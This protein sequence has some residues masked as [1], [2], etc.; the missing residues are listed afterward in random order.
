MTFSSI[1]FIFIFLWI[2]LAVY[3]IVP[4]RYRNL[5]LLVMSLVFY[6]WG[7]PSAVFLMV[8]TIVFDYAAGRLLQ[9]YSGNGRA[10]KAVLAVCVCVNIGMLCFFKYAGL[11]VSTANSVLGAGLDVPEVP[12]PVGIS[13]YM[14]ES[15]SYVVD[16]YRGDAPAQG[17][18]IN[19]GTY[20]SLYPHLVAGPI[21]RYRDM[22]PQLLGRRETLRKFSE[23]GER[24]L[25]G[26]FK[27]VLLAN[28]LAVIADKVKYFGD[29]SFLS[30]WLAAL[31]FTFQIYFDFS[32]Y[33]D[34][35]I[36]LGK[37]FGFD[38]P[39]NFN[40]PYAA[41][42]ASEFWR[43]WHMTLGNWF[44]EYLYFPLGG[45]RCSKVKM[46]RNLAIVWV[47]TGMWHG[48]SWN[49]AVW[50]AYWG[51]LIICEKLFLQK[52]LDAAP[53]FLQWLY[54]FTAAVVGWVFFSHTDIASAAVNV[55]AMF[56]GAR[57][58]DKLGL[59]TLVTGAPLLAA[60]ALFSTPLPAKLFGKLR[61]CGTGGRVVW[62]VCYGCL[63]VLCV[64]ALANNSYNPFLYA[65][66]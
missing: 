15:V 38:L 62:C 26:L 50:G 24:F 18:V 27:K 34:M 48:G 25:R 61:S 53:R 19:F 57:F 52:R 51:L 59:Y 36:G 8:F 28:N 20:L 58:A 49:F 14:F 56:G 22:E 39:E 42:S 55:A 33:S 63:F 10:A 37:M 54:G 32:G 29:P 16:V 30:A 21:I 3:Y 47:L 43:R 5:A 60:A 23:G 4:R 11:L 46:V 41:R 6:A 2:S 44:K 65:K 13:F 64:A 1:F 17:S 9:R 31:A 40:Y 35:A 7:E 45:S 12:L 66:F